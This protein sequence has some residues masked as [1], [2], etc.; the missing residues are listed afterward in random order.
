MF[1]ERGYPN[2]FIEKIEQEVIDGRQDRFK[3]ILGDTAGLRMGKVKLVNNEGEENF[4]TDFNGDAVWLRKTLEEEWTRFGQISD[5]EVSEGDRSLTYDYNVRMLDELL[6]KY[7]NME[8]ENAYLKECLK[9]KI[10]PKGLR[11]YKYPNKVKEGTEFHKELLQIF[12]NC[13]FEIIKAIMKENEK[14]MECIYGKMDE[15]NHKITNDLM[16]SI[17]D[18]KRKYY[19]ILNKIEGKIKNVYERK[20]RKI[21]RDVKEYKD[22][23]NY[24]K[25]KEYFRNRNNYAYE[26]EWGQGDLPDVEVQEMGKEA[27]NIN[28]PFAF[29]PLRRSFT[30]F[31]IHVFKKRFH[32]RVYRDMLAVIFAISEINQNDR[33]LPNISMGFRIYDSCYSEIKALQSALYLLSGKE[34]AVPNYRCQS[35]P[36]LLGIIGDVA[37]SLSITLARLLGLHRFPQISHGAV[38]SILSNKLDFSSFLRTI[39]GIR[40]QDY[41]LAQLAYYFRWTW[42]GIL[43][44]DNDIGETSTQ[45]LKNEIQKNG[46]CVAFIEI[47]HVLYSKQRVHKIVELVIKSSANIVIINSDEVH[48]KATLD[49]LYAINVTGKT[50]ILSG[51]CTMTPGYFTKETWTLLNGTLGLA[52]ST[53]DMPGFRHFLYN[54]KPSSSPKDIFIRTFWKVYFGCDWAIGN[55]S[56]TAV[57][58]TVSDERTYCTGAESINNL[59]SDLFEL[60]DLSYTFHAYLAVYAFAHAFS[61]IID[62]KPGYGPFLNGSCSS[63]QDLLPWQVFHYVKHVKFHTDSGDEIIFDVNG[64]ALMIYDIINVQI[65]KMDVYKFIKIGRINPRNP[66]GNEISINTSAVLWTEGYNQI[67]RSVCSGSCPVGYRKSVREGQPACCFDC[68]P[69]SA[70]EI[71]NQT[72]ANDC[73]MCQENQWTNDRRDKCVPKTFEFLAYEE[74]LTIV[75]IAIVCFL[76]FTTVSIFCIFIKYRDTPI[77]KANNQ[78]LSYLLLL[79]LKLCFLCSLLFIGRPWKVTCMLRQTVFGITFSICLASVLAKTITVVIAF[80]VKN[81]NSKLRKWM[82]VKIPYFIILCCST[83]QVILCAIWLYVSPPF[84]KMDIHSPSR[85]IIL[86]CNEGQTSFFYCMLGY[87]GFLATVCFTVAFLA[88]VLPDSFNEA[89]HITFSMLVFVSVWLSFIPAYLSTKGKYMVAVEIFAILSSSAGLLICIFSFKCYIILLRPHLNTKQHLIGKK[90][91]LHAEK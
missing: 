56:Q 80:K 43:T 90:T 66:K 62:C 83:V 68:S 79:S 2:E 45:N 50:F 55:I 24:P 17:E 23:V 25:P 30:S 5:L 35:F 12:D 58:E 28:D 18:G 69:C 89:K 84:P 63:I 6:F 64:D 52:P 33:I 27:Y 40:F 70:G 22:K 1:K 29:P 82:G 59:S 49:A 87:M 53:T 41:A 67:P 65:P 20:S 76:C 57:S 19:E 32:I 8:I 77:V 73:V 39:P 36:F 51:L 54:L 75:L 88:R 61:D 15:I 48:A 74:P 10:V 7:K 37:S 9:L 78:V 34:S 4:V 71:T 16:F 21:K 86:E 42:I 14:D 26:E 85:Q 46:A 38:H 31:D 13:G 72:D 81:P 47:M 3:P 60:N 44:S 91:F 11:V